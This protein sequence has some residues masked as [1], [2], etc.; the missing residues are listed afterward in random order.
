MYGV[1]LTSPGVGRRRGNGGMHLG[2][3][4]PAANLPLSR[5]VAGK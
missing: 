1:T 4:G 5:I 2:A 3:G